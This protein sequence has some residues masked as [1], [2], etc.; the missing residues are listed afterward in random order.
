MTMPNDP[1]PYLD[2][3]DERRAAAK[4]HIAVVSATVRKAAL[5]VPLHADIDDF[6]RVLA[7]NAPKGGK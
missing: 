6:R 5:D 7:A 2:M 4:A 3:P 1:A